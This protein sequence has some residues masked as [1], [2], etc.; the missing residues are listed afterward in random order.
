MPGRVV[1]FQRVV[2]LGEGMLL[3]EP[4]APVTKAARDRA[5]K[6]HDRDDPKHDEQGDSYHHKGE[7]RVDLRAKR[8]R[9]PDPADDRKS[10]PETGAAPGS[11]GQ[12]KKPGAPFSCLADPKHC[13]GPGSDREAGAER[14]LPT[15]FIRA[16]L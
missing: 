6:Q 9:T 12:E 13:A 5:E 14:L 11:P 1:K 16:N 15:C 8:R 7:G 2:A 3:Q 4:L 10:I